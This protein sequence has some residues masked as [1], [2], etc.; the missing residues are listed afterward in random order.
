MITTLNLH[1][2]IDVNSYI[3]SNFGSDYIFIVDPGANFAYISS[4]IKKNNYKPYGILLTD[5]HFDHIGAVN[6]L[7]EKYNV[8]VLCS[9]NA[10]TYLTNP[11]Y[12]LSEY[13]T[14]KIIINSFQ[15]IDEDILTLPGDIPLSLRAFHTPG[16]TTDSM[17]YY[18]EQEGWAVTGDTVFKDSIG[19]THYPG[20]NF[21]VLIN[22]IKTVILNLPENTILYT[23]HGEPT[24]PSEVR[25]YL[26]TVWIS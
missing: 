24:T 4:V 12:N 5:G 15:A 23:G 9:T 16:H 19:A 11:E 25:N 21:R 20:G 17:I 8:P 1:G 14:E 18:C 13:C 6:K 3:I 2:E 26:S 10:Q 7:V 22:S